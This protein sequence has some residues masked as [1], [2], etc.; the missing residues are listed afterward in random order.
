VVV[1]RHRV[2]VVFA[3]FLFALT[4]FLH[5]IGAMSRRHNKGSATMTGSSHGHGAVGSS[6]GN[7]L[8]FVRLAF[9]SLPVLDHPLA[10][11]FSVHLLSVKLNELVTL[12]VSGSSSAGINLST[13]V[14]LAVLFDQ[15]GTFAFFS[16]AVFLV[17]FKLGLARSFRDSEVLG[18]AGI[19]QVFFVSC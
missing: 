17:F 6:D 15:F 16:L 7:L 10:H 4:Q 3:F 18:F 1:N 14:I 8:V 2:E 9:V 12:A 13:V 5:G 11:L 19:E